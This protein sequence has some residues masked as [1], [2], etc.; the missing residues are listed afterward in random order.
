MP[1]DEYAIEPNADNVLKAIVLELPEGVA[2]HAIPI[3]Q[4]E[5]DRLRKENEELKAKWES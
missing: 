1:D 3:I 5:L 2:R 4:A